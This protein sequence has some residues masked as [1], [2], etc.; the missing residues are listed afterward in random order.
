MEEKE[1]K[2]RNKSLMKRPVTRSAGI[3]LSLLISMHFLTSC[4]KDRNN[5]MLVLAP[6]LAGG[7]AV[8]S[9][10]SSPTSPSSPPASPSSPATPFPT[11][12][13][14][15]GGN[16]TVTVTW[17]AVSGATSYNL[18]WSTTS[19]VTKATGTKIPGVTSPYAH[20]ALTNGS[21]YYYIVT[22]VGPGGESGA[23]AEV[24]AYPYLS[25]LKTYQTTSYAAGDDGAIQAG[26][27]TNFTGPVDAGGGAFIT[28]DNDTG[29]VWKTC[30]EG[31]S[32]VNCATGTAVTMSWTT[33][34]G[35]GTG[36]GCDALNGGA[37]FAGRT[38]WR[39]PTLEEIETIANYGTTA[40]FIFA[41]PFPGTLSNIYWSSTP[42]ALNANNIWTFEFVTGGTSVSMNTALNYV[43]CVTQGP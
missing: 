22:A 12:V 24:T 18:Y 34:T 21:D 31:L 38:G 20:T 42:Y 19:G 26:R 23:S 41:V 37:G 11:G 29:L 3:I 33:A 39:L 27:I 30:T 6:L 28:T 35:T 8:P 43:R 9:P 25:P 16:R 4:K 7:A 10:S 1:M 36:T 14:A 17:G 13:S 5:G 2:L 40:P 32:G 15:T